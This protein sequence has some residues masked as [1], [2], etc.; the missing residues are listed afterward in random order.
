MSGPYGTGWG[1]PDLDPEEK[2]EQWLKIVRG[3]LWVYGAGC[4]LA[5][6]SGSL[7]LPWLIWSNPA[8]ESRGPLALVTGVLTGLFLGLVAAWPI[9]TAVGLGRRRA[10]AR[11][12]TIVLGALLLPGMCLPLGAFFLYAMFQARVVRLFGK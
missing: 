12:S 4:A 8:L 3:L 10:W 9:A 2:G 7:G 11:V 1:D 5:A 6:C